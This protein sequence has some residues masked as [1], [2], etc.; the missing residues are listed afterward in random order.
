VPGGG[1]ER[2][3]G[4]AGDA[5][6]G[7]ECP[8]QGSEDGVVDRRRQGVVADQRRDEVLVA[9][10]QRGAEDGHAERAADLQ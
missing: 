4:G 5:C 8:A 6:G 9:E 1:G 2:G 10:V 7:L 3:A